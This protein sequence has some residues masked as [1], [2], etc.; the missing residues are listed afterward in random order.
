MT[1]SLVHQNQPIE[2]VEDLGRGLV[3]REVDAGA[4]VS[5][6]LEDV[7]QRHR[8]ERVPV[9]TWYVV[10]VGTVKAKGYEL[11]A[12]RGS[13]ALSFWIRFPPD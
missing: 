8:R 5:G 2:T 11:G 1:R 3:D 7:A 6:L 4:A 10:S 9:C 13:H 12:L